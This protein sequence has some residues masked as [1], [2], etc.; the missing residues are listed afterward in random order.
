MERGPKKRKRGPY[1]TYLNPK[2]QFQLPRSTARACPPTGASPSM[3]SSSDEADSDTERAD[4]PS[5]TTSLKSRN[6]HIASPG[7]E[8]PESE[9]DFPESD[10]EP[11]TSSGGRL[12]S[13]AGS[14]M[15]APAAAPEAQEQRNSADPSQKFPARE[16]H[17]PAD[18]DSPLQDGIASLSDADDSSLFDKD[19]EEAFS[20]DHA[21][22]QGFPGDFLTLDDDMRA[23]SPTEL[24]IA[25]GLLLE[26]HVRAELLFGKSQW[27]TSLPDNTLVN[28]LCKRP[29]TSSRKLKIVR[30]VTD[31]QKI[32]IA[33]MEILSGKVQSSASFTFSGSIT[34]SG[35]SSST[36]TSVVAAVNLVQHLLQELGSS[37]KP[38]MPTPD[39]AA[40][41][42]IAGYISR[43]V[44]NC[45]RCVSLVLKAK[46]SST[47]A[48]DGLISHPDRGG[49]C[50]HTA[51][52]VRVFVDV[53]LL[54]RAALLKPLSCVTVVTKSKGAN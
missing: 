28:Y 10:N 53:M 46:G 48:T 33:A 19:E 18:E 25:E 51:E 47:S 38:F 34:R 7:S 36:S 15:E 32:N 14:A 30:A 8:R 5:R 3:P 21:S 12:G 35:E 37:T 4:P 27:D 9:E 49:L 11:V 45:E 26:F 41:S 20:S 6:S 44:S 2:S 52:L 39:I 29:S 54:H 43:V 22:Q 50:Y 42:L 31:N 24:T 23:I 1:K 16:P 40:V 13:S 17:A